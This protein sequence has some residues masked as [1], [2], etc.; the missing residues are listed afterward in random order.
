M[1]MA[2]PRSW[3]RLIGFD[4]SVWAAL[5]Q[6]AREAL[7]RR[8]EALLFAVLLLGVALAYG[9][10]LATARGPF[11]LLSFGGVLAL[12]VNLLRLATAGGGAPHGAGAYRPGLGPLLWL[13]LLS[14]VAAQ[15]AQLL[16]RAAGPAHG[17]LAA[18]LG[19]LWAE[20][21][22]AAWGTLAYAALAV[23]PALLMHLAARPALTAYEAVRRRRERAR[24]ASTRFR[25]AALLAGFG[26][27]P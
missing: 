19:A 14:L 5:P 21:W 17:R 18:A 3:S 2:R 7:E 27:A 26:K 25:V 15:P 6:G 4:P 22:G 20:P 23:G 13:G 12:L 24:V 16:A 8:S 10:Q 11:A 9:A 1:A